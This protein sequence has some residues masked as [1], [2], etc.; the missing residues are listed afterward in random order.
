MKALAVVVVVVGIGLGVL[1]ATRD[2]ERSAARS[3]EEAPA[4][5]MD[6]VPQELAPAVVAAGAAEAERREATDVPAAE[7]SPAS[8]PQP[9]A[10]A[11]ASVLVFRARPAAP[12]AA[13]MAGGT[14]VGPRGVTPRRATSGPDGEV[15]LALA[16]ASIEGERLQLEAS[17]PGRL[18]RSVYVDGRVLANTAEHFLGEIVLAPGG[19]LAGRVVDERG[20]PVAG[21]S[22]I[23]RPPVAEPH[24][25][26]RVLLPM[27]WF[28]DGV[29]VEGTTGAEG[30]YRLDGVPCGE[31]EVLASDKLRLVAR[32]APCSV[33]AG[34][35]TRLPDLVL[36]EADDADRI[37][38]LVLA[39]DG[40]PVAGVFVALLAADENASYGG[41]PSGPDGRFTLLAPRDRTYVLRATDRETRASVKARDVLTGGR[42]V[43]LR[44]GARTE[45]E[46]AVRDADGPIEAFRAVVEDIDR[47]GLSGHASHAPGLARI[48]LPAE[49]FHVYVISPLHRAERVG[50]FEPASAPAGIE[51]ELERAGGIAGVVLAGGVPVAGAE[52]HA[53]GALE[54]G[55]LHEQLAEG[56]ATFVSPMVWASARTGADGRFFLAL[57]AAGRYRVH[58]SA[59]GYGRAASARLAYLDGARID[60]LELALPD[61][62]AIAGRLLV[63]PEVDP[64]GRWI[65]ASDGEGHVALAQTD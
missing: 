11:V 24:P 59:R 61:A 62:G 35:E 53:H 41:V 58:A 47:R 54:D 36:E 29:R 31:V 25:G 12:E 16:R 50:P 4:A 5:R 14:L 9:A 33:R 48:A 21:A 38:G 51:V 55:E 28:G 7:A 44:F 63:A 10:T 18:R 56:F 46:V 8:E 15:A 43:V 20:A 65:G 49:P 45:I 37:R 6:V 17:A 40:A 13:P 27:S 22:V 34:E 2:G 57:R 1:W 52:V 3:R 32:S 30:G 60:G 26:E 19:S 42:E 23:V 39:A 64:R